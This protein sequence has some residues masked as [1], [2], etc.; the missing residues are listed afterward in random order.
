MEHIFSQPRSLA[1]SDCGCDSQLKLSTY[2]AWTS[3]IA[4]Y[5]MDARGVPRSSL[6][7]QGQVFLLS[8]SSVRFLKPAEY[9]MNCTLRTWEHKLQ[10]VQFIRHYSLDDENGEPCIQSVSSWFLADP[11]NRKVIR[12]SEYVHDVLTCD[13]PVAAE[14]RRLRLSDFPKVAEH[15][16]LL[17]ELDNNQHMNNRFYGDLLVNYAPA[18]LFGLPLVSADVA[19]VHEAYLGETIHIHAAQTAEDTYAMYGELTGGKRCFDAQAQVKLP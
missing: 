16:V 18:P 6:L 2:L 3:E 14:L 5:Q 13:E 8:K 9:L 19:Y 1:F 11:V 10:G 12:P 4:G 17:T 7:E 15:T